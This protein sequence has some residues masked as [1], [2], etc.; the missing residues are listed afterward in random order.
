MTCD[1]CKRETDNVE[2]WI[3][4]NGCTLCAVRSGLDRS[5]RWCERCIVA[6][7]L[8]YANKLAANI[9]M[10]EARLSD[11]IGRGQE[12]PHDD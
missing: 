2:I 9:P 7:Q 1:H 10:L 8:A 5:P 3:G 11:L 6:A 4:E 12:A